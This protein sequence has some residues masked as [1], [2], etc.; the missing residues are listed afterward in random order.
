M[1]TPAGSGPVLQ[2]NA[3]A[4]GPRNFP[5]RPVRGPAGTGPRLSLLGTFSFPN[6]ITDAS[7]MRH[8][9]R[10]VRWHSSISTNVQPR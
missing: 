2:G 10:K 1:P 4:L 3:Q 6:Q 8:E 5:T 9:R 7:T